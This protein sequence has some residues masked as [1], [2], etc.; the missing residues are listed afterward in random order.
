MKARILSNLQKYFEANISKHQTNI[1]I[2]LNNPM[3]IHEHV[4]YV[5]A[6]ENELGKM[7]EY[8]DKLEVLKQYFID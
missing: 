6:I 4:D 2:M 7:A 8:V 5:G 3:A 1:E